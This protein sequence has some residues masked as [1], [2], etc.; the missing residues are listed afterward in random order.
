MFHFRRICPATNPIALESLSDNQNVINMKKVKTN[1]Q[2]T[3]IV[4]IIETAVMLFNWIT[5]GLI[6]FWISLSILYLILLPYFFLMNTSHNKERVIEYGWKNVIWNFIGRKLRVL[7]NLC[8]HFRN[9]DLVNEI[10]ISNIIAAYCFS[11]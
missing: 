6:G 5:F 4:C 9:K 11:N 10:F 3:S 2:V 1:A 8:E 7:M